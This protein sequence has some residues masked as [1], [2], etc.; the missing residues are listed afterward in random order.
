M[1]Y[2]DEGLNVDPAA[3]KP[4]ISLGRDDP[5]ALLDPKSVTPTLGSVE[6][7]IAMQLSPD[8]NNSAHSD[9]P[10]VVTISL[11]TIDVAFGLSILNQKDGLLDP[12][13]H[14]VILTSEEKGQRAY[15]RDSL[16]HLQ[17]VVNTAAANGV[18]IE[19]PNN[20]VLDASRIE[21]MARDLEEKAREAQRQAEED[22]K[23]REQEA[24][25]TYRQLMSLVAAG[26]V[27]G[28]N[29]AVAALVTKEFD[30]L[31]K[32]SGVASYTDLGSTGL[33]G[34]VSPSAG[35]SRTNNPTLEMLTS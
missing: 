23:K 7:A 33:L 20:L 9:A 3:D 15:M 6:P 2:G 22:A 24:P 13:A 17:Q 1:A 8:P 10:A 34:P 5:N 14:N 28:L 21:N 31:G 25:E 18:R 26:A 35:G 32:N 12:N 16:E 30:L 29:P 27:G 19:I 4:K 11:N